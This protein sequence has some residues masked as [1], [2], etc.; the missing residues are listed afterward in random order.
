[1]IALITLVLLTIFLIA[2]LNNKIFKARII[3]IEKIYAEMEGDC[4]VFLEKK[5]KSSRDNYDLREQL[6]KT[7]ALYDITKNI[8]KHLDEEKVFA[9]FKEEINK[10]VKVDDCRFLKS[11]EDLSA[12]SGYD[13]LSLEINKKPV[14]Y[15]VSKGIAEG[16]DDKFNIL[17]QQFALGIKR[18]V[19]YRRIQELAI[20]DSL[21]NSFSRSYWQERFNQEIERS[22]KFKYQFSFLMIDIDHFKAVNDRYGHLVGDGIL[23]EVAKRIKDTIRQID[24]I[25]RYG[26]EEFSVILIETDRVGARF[27]AGRILQAVEE[28]CVKVYDE[29]LKITVSIGISVFPE[30]ASDNKGLIEKADKALYRAKETGRNK[31]CLHGNK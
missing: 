6:D 4:G 30:D 29:D 31:V 12:Y 17:A 22:R 13:I 19:L 9:L 2:F 7:I 15:L 20:T 14:G 3:K 10:Y 1:M 24:L 16:E 21:T 8:C 5:E 27:A 11:S 25:C 28:K 18:A 26:G 23:K